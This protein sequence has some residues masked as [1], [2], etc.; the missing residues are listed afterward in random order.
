MFI[1]PNT[2]I[3][4]LKERFIV[5]NIDVS[6]YPLILV[7][8]RTG[9]YVLGIGLV[10]TTCNQSTVRLVIGNPF[11]FGY[12]LPRRGFAKRKALTLARTC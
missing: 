10:S 7:F 2:I 5:F 6:K 11:G 4:K 3:L 12:A 9:T 8:A 1:Q